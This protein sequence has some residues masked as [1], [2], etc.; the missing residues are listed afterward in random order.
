MAWPANQSNGTVYDAGDY[1]E[2][3]RLAARLDVQTATLSNGAN[4]NVTTNGRGVLRITGPTAAFSITGLAGGV[5]GKRIHIMNRVA[6]E[7]TLANESAS[8][9]AANRIETQTGSDI[10]LAGRKSSAI[11]VYDATDSRW[12]VVATL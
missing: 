12:V 9:T 3:L 10:I 2:L 6:Q 11:L 5:E 4:H 8:S 7:M 1:T